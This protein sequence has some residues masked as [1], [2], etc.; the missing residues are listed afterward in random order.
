MGGRS[1]RSSRNLFFLPGSRRF[2]IEENVIYYV[3]VS[4]TLAWSSS[5]AQASLA[6]SSST[7][8]GSQPAGPAETERNCAAR[9]AARLVLSFWLLG[10]DARFPQ[11]PSSEATLELDTPQCGAA[12]RNSPG[13]RSTTASTCC[14]AAGGS[15]IASRSSAHAASPCSRAAIKWRR[16]RCANASASSKWTPDRVVTGGIGGTMSESSP[17]SLEPSVESPSSRNRSTRRRRSPARNSNARSA[18]AKQTR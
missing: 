11:S 5:T 4:I 8:M 18:V 16:T 1:G 7:S 12:T 15:C 6:A 3:S 14:K 9:L 17:L 2:Y 13:C 10:D